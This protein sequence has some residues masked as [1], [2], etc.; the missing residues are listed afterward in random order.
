MEASSKLHSLSKNPYDILEEERVTRI[1]PKIFPSSAIELTTPA[2][3]SSLQAH[4]NTTAEVSH[5]RIGILGINPILKQNIIGLCSETTGCS[6]AAIASTVA[7]EAEGLLDEVC[8]EMM[9]MCF[10]DDVTLFGGDF[11]YHHIIESESVDAIYVT[12]QPR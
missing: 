10:R 11:A 9:G 1:P 12:I 6:L 7:G 8:S 5:L 4:K 3:S 2:I